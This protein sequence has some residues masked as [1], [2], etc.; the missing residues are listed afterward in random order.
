MLNN[1]LLLKT[2]TPICLLKKTN[3]HQQHIYQLNIEHYE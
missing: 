3:Y 2:N 1:T